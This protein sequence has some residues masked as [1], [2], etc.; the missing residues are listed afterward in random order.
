MADLDADGL[1]H[2]ERLAVGRPHLAAEEFDDAADAPVDGDREP[3]RAV[4]LRLGGVARA[5]EVRVVE[6][7]RD[8]RGPPGGPHASRQADPGGEG[9]VPADALELV[10]DGV[11]SPDLDASQSARALVDLPDGAHLPAKALAERSQDSGRG[12]VE[13]GRVGEDGGDGVLRGQVLLGPQAGGDV[14]GDA[15]DHRGEAVEVGDD[16]L[17]DD[18]L[19]PAA[20]GPDQGLAG[21]NSGPRVQRS[22]VVVLEAMGDVGREDLVVGLPVELRASD[23]E[24]DLGEIVHIDVSTVGILDPGE[25]GQMAHEALEALLAVAKR[26]AEVRDLVRAAPS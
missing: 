24:G 13:G 5:R 17:A 16:E 10:R 7:V 1:E 12:L 22:L 2:L 4:Q 6:D 26:A 9:R 18:R 3:D 20:V 15:P 11:G 25:P 8:P 14:E 23:A 21:L 19:A